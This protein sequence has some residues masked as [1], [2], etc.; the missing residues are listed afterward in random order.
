MEWPNEN[1]VRGEL[2]MMS[3]VRFAWEQLEAEYG[4]Q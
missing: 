1:R 4:T 3:V 2:L